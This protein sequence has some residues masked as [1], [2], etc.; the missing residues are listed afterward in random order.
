METIREKRGLSIAG[1]AGK[2]RDLLAR[3]WIRKFERLDVQRL[4][5]WALQQPSRRAK[6]SKWLDFT[7]A[8]REKTTALAAIE[9]PRFLRIV[10]TYGPL[11]VCRVMAPL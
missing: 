10:S 6:R 2:L 8:R 1:T 5:L 11:P 4:E 7:A 9:M 3:P